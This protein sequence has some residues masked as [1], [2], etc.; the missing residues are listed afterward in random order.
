MRLSSKQ[1]TTL[2]FSILLIIFP[3]PTNSGLFSSNQPVINVN[4]NVEGTNNNTQSTNVSQSSNLKNN[5]LQ[6][7]QQNQPANPGDNPEEKKV[8]WKEVLSHYKYHIIGGTFIAGYVSFFALVLADHNYVHRKDTWG[9]WK[10]SIS[11]DGLY[12]YPKNQ[13]MNELIHAIQR[14]HIL[15]DPTDAS[16]SFSAFMSAIEY[17]IFRTKRYIRIS[18]FLQRTK[19]LLIFPTNATTL[20]MARDK[21]RRI[22]FLKESFV[23]WAASYKMQYQLK[24]GHQALGTKSNGA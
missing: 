6:N 1:S 14:D 18:S 9:A 19:L 7:Q 24:L 2:I 3:L 15:A 23:S 17:E 22:H 12:Q 16:A 10:H 8:N 21:L 11:I 20:K 4:V 5:S 13:L